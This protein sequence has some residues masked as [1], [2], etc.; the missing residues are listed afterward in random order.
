MNFDVFGGKNI[1]ILMAISMVLDFVVFAP[2][3]MKVSVWTGQQTG[4][5]MLYL[6]ELLRSDPN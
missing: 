4:P 6:L 3:T 1:E 5:N 2:K